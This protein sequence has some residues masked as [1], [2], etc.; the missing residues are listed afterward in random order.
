MIG[1]RHLD[2]KHLPPDLAKNGFFKE[3]DSTQ[4]K[5]EMLRTNATTKKS[6]VEV[7]QE[8]NF[9]RKA[10]Y[11]AKERFNEDGLV[12]LIDRLPGPRGRHKVDSEMEETIVRIKREH[13]NDPKFKVPQVFQALKEEYTERCLPVNISTKTVERVLID[14]GLHTPRSKKNQGVRK[15]NRE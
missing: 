8:F 9:S 15:K 14:H 13:M 1:V 3:S 4:V 11:N 10:F 7:C 2:K 12:G 6:V 5:Y